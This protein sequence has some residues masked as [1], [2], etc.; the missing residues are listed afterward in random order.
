MHLTLKKAVFL[1]V[2][3]VV[4]F[5]YS[6]IVSSSQPVA[7]LETTKTFSVSEALPETAAKAYAVFDLET[8]EVLL[9]K[10]I[11][12]VL[13]IASITKLFTAAVINKSFNQGE[14][15]KITSSDVAA[16][17]GAGKLA[18][19]QEFTYHDLLFPLLLESS[20]DAAAAFERVTSGEVVVEMNTLADSAGALATK[21]ADASGLSDRNVSTAS[22]LMILLSYLNQNEKHVLDITSLKK[23][24]GPHTGWLNNSP[25]MTDSYQGGKHGYTEA[26]N[27]TVAALFEETFGNEKRT[28]GYIILG[29]PDLKKDMQILRSFLA[30]EVTYE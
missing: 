6:N 22:D 19:G 30:T 4:A 20:N 7:A 9:A 18:A 29:S 12:T 21:F 2:A 27:R 13:P 25:V 26:A 11:D 3:L 16:E 23:Y 1:S 8:G 14:K 15:I 10:N 24:V 28:V 5:A 17:G